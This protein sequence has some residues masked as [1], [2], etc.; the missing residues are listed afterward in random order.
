MPSRM[1]RRGKPDRDPSPTDSHSWLPEASRFG[2]VHASYRL[3]HYGIHLWAPSDSCRSKPFVS[4]VICTYGRPESLNDTL[5]SLSQQT[6]RSFE[7]I[8]VTP[9]GHL[10]E[11]RDQGLRAAA[12]SIVVFIDD[13]VYCPAT[14]LKNVAKVFQERPEVV[15][16]SGPTYIKEEFRNRRDL[17]KYKWAKRLYDL[18]FLEGKANLPGKLSRCGAP[19][20]GSNDDG[21]SY[22]G[23]VD[24]L[25]A[26][27]MSVRR[28]E[29]LDVGGFDTSYTRT[30]EWCE[31]DLSRKLASR[32]DLWFCP[33]ANLE[34][35]PSQAGI[36]AGRLQTEHRWH[37]FVYFQNKWVKVSFKR[38]TY[39][40]FICLYL[41]MK[42]LRM[43]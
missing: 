12:G 5:Q 9:K 34:H 6:Y 37:N 1:V 15:G 13:D 26:C 41:K 4:I 31:V 35:R 18:W 23:K 30:S 7:V 28:V 24:Y 11:L 19:T 3:S 32:G 21:C 2:M 39:W 17:F 14:W 25:E 8:L 16:L 38:F 27:N 43:I 22:E 20:T 10:S 29:A 42:S 40:V 36:Y 33:Q